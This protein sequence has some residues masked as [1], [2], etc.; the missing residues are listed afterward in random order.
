MLP[1]LAEKNLN[2]LYSDFI[3]IHIPLKHGFN[4]VNEDG[5]S[6]DAI[7]ATLHTDKKI[8]LIF[9]ALDEYNET[10]IAHIKDRVWAYQNKY[11]NSKAIITT[12]P[13]HNFQSLGQPDN[14][15][16]LCL[17]TVDQVNEFYQRYGIALDYKT[18]AASGLESDEICKPLFCWMI[19]LAY[20]KNKSLVVSNDTNLNRVWLFYTVI[21]DII[22][23]KHVSESSKYGYTKHALDEKLALGKIA[24]L[25]HVYGDALTKK[26]ILD[27][28]EQLRFK[29]I[30][31]K[32]ILKIFDQLISSYFYTS[33]GAGYTEHIDFI[34]RS[35]EEYLL[36]EFYIECALRNETYRVNMK[37]PTE[38]TVQFFDGLLN[39]LNTQNKKL[40]EYAE[41]LANTYGFTDLTT[42]KNKLIINST[43]FFGNEHVYLNNSNKKKDYPTISESYENLVLHRW[44]SIAVLNRL[45]TFHK[46]DT[47]IFFKLLKASHGSV[48]NY[49]I[50]ID[51][52][53]LS[54]H[55]FDDEDDIPNYNLSKAHLMNTTF[56]R[57]FYGT[58]FA[59]AELTGSK[60]K[61]RY[62]F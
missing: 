12:R 56:H 46:L 9:D 25:K 41:K 61:Q 15:V 4:R 34:H 7:L 59:G 1:Y 55:E 53:D 44:L 52:I 32:E 19:S 30:L 2:E 40:G 14:Y 28:L 57:R 58:K 29:K 5:D 13:N 45:G 47:K 31:N 37:L 10:E 36:A 50:R 62:I 35:F 17:F 48:P 20:V 38:V 49:L 26:R 33:E 27:L 39:L 6:L 43:S 8:L 11:M 16:R 18:V 3:P 42:L 24:E 23:G 60:I 21:H 54:G 51:N 22:L